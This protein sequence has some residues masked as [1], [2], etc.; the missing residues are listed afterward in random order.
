MKQVKDAV[1]Q[2]RE[3]DI[4]IIH[5]VQ[6]RVCIVFK[7]WVEVHFYDFVED[8]ELTNRLLAFIEEVPDNT[9][10][11]IMQYFK[12]SHL[13]EMQKTGQSLKMAIK[14][15]VFPEP[16]T[17]GTSSKLLTSIVDLESQ[18]QGAPEP[19]L[20]SLFNGEHFDF[21]DLDP[22]EISRQLCVSTVHV[23]S[24][25]LQIIEFNKFSKIPPKEFLNQKW[26]KPD[27]QAL[28]PGTTFFSSVLT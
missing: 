1:Q 15:K 21:I 13:E 11:L 7:K 14:K 24:H 2:K 12:N 23:V 25:T 8:I 19:I 5:P 22:L 3:S 6:L 20:P 17:E 26:N 28:A 10:M 4:N 16:G 9:A 18:L 27:K